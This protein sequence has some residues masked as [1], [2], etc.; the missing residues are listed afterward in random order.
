MFLLG[1]LH[2]LHNIKARPSMVMKV[3][4]ADLLLR[5]GMSQ[6]TW[7]DGVITVADRFET[8]SVKLT[9]YSSC[10]IIGPLSHPDLI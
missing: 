10:I 8:L 5:L 9:S 3:K 4:K 6:D 2:N 7:V 1:G